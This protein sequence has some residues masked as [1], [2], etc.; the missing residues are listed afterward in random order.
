MLDFINYPNFQ[1]FMNKN[2]LAIDFGAKVIG[3]AAFCPG[4]E[5][6]PIG[7]GRIVNT[8]MDKFLEELALI[9]EDDFIEVI[10][11]GVPYLVD[12]GETEKTREM[13]NKFNRVKE[14]FPTIEVIEQD[15]TLTTSAAKERMLNSAQYNFQVDLK[16]IDEVAAIIILEDFIRKT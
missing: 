8:G 3:L 6:F 10:I 15:E 13:R 5:P 7:R 2:M 16:K 1:K 11:F 14:K 12:G 9:V 4:R